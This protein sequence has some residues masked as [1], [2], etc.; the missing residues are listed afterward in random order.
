[1]SGTLTGIGPILSDERGSGSV[2]ALG[3]VCAVV[4]VAAGGLALAG[5]GAAGARAAAAADLAALA[6]ADVAAGRV[7]GVPC[8]IADAVAR[9]NGATLQ[10]CDQTGLT[11]TV[12][13][14]TPYLDLAASASARAGPPGTHVPQSKTVSR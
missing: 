3:I 10:A 7:A 6:A 14:T 8:E 2:L 9:A 12:T 4:V 13:A 11:V 1:M 5:A